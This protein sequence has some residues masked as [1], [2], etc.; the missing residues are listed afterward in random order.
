MRRLVGLAGT[1]PAADPSTNR[2]AERVELTDVDLALGP[3]FPV[4]R[5]GRRYRVTFWWS[6][7]PVAHVEVEPD[8]ARSFDAEDWQRLVAEAVAPDVMRVAREIVAR[9]AVAPPASSTAS[10]VI[11]TRDR[12]EQLARCL[13]SLPQQTQRAAEVIVVD[14]ASRDMRTRDAALRANAVYVREDRPGLDY[15]RNA[16]ALAARGDIVAYTDDDVRLH[17]RW[18]ERMVA[19]FD[20]PS[21]A[22]VTGLVLPA[23]LETSAQRHFETHWSFG[24]GYRR[25]DFA[26]EFFAADRTHGCPVWEIGAGASMAFRRD[27]FV[28]AGLFDE[29]LDVGRAGCSGD[30]E[31]WHRILTHGR[32][33]RYEPS[34]VVFH[35]HRRDWAGLSRQIEAY[36]RGHA[37]ALM[38]Q[39][40]RSG[41]LG[42][43]RRA[44]VT[45]PLYYAR[46]LCRL[47]LRS[48]RPEDRF[49][50]KEAAG[51]LAGLLFYA[52]EANWRAL[53]GQ[54]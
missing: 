46:R 21:I 34:A 1:A 39:Y 2:D 9:E 35:Y 28:T 49:L 24:R 33:C 48:K 36:M 14:N 51:F 7:C 50:Y 13:A 43:L 16:G 38:V 20:Q 30:S 12:P 42:H 41:H 6:D 40:E 26:D 8:S 15:A 11:C 23:E 32:V 44:G 45:M 19:A 52:R 5:A 22:A 25:I 4:L 29:R 53:R 3:D 54:R 27:I 31:F 17:P 18:L 37:A 10:V 47:M